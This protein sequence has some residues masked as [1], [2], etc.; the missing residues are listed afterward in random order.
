MLKN[1]AISPPGAQE[2]RWGFNADG[3][4]CSTINMTSKHKLKNIWGSWKAIPWGD[5]DQ[6]THRHMDRA[7]A[8]LSTRANND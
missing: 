5:T 2:A 7:R 3:V 8:L 4:S 1:P 6:Q